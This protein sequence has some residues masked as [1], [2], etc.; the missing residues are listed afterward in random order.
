MR[1][2]RLGRLLPEPVLRRL[3]SG[4]AAPPTESGTIIT[5]RITRM[6]SDGPADSLNHFDN[7]YPIGEVPIS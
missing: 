2:Y 4:S 1:L 5:R 3:Y 6:R 7:V